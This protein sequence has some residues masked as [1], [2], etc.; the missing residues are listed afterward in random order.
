MQLT[1]NKLSII[2]KVN[3][4]IPKI[5]AA[6]G[7]IQY[8]ALHLYTYVFIS[9]LVSDPIYPLPA[10][11]ITALVHILVS[12]FAV[13]IYQEAFGKDSENVN[14]ILLASLGTTSLANATRHAFADDFNVLFTYI[15]IF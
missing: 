5:T 1:M 11:M 9:K 3:W 10:I 2:L 8:P 6:G 12:V 7:P 14:L 4:T 15:A 13:K